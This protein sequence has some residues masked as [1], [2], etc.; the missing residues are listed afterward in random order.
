MEVRDYGLLE[1][2]LGDG[3][4]GVFTLRAPG[5]R[6]SPRLLKTCPEL[7]ASWR[8]LEALPDCNAPMRYDS[9]GPVR[10]VQALWLDELKSYEWRF[11]GPSE[12]SCSLQNSTRKADWQRVDGDTEGEWGGTLK[13][14][15]CLGTAWLGCGDHKFRFEVVTRKLSYEQ[16]YRAMVEAIARECQQLLL[17]WDAPTSLSVSA[18]AEK[19][20]RTLL[21]QFLF[22]RHVMGPDRLDVFV[23]LLQRRPHSRL[24]S[25]RH[26][27]PAAA[28]DPRL[29]IRDPLRHGRD[30]QR[31]PT[32]LINGFSPGEVCTERKFDTVDTPPNRFVKFALGRFASL[33]AQVRAL[34]AIASGQG[35]AWLEAGQMEASLESLLAAPFFHEVGELRRIPLE[36]QTLQKRAGYRDVL[37]AWLML[38]AAAQIDW[39]GRKDAYDG[40]NRNVAT[41]YEFW[42]YFTLVKMLRDNLSMVPVRDPL[43]KTGD[44]WLPFCCESENGGMAINLKQSCTSFSRFVWKGEN[45]EE[46]L[47]HLFYN[48]RF[49]GRTDV[50]KSGAYSRGFRPDFT[51]VILPAD[52]TE[53]DWRQAERDGEKDG[54]IAYLHFDAKYRIE[55]ITELLGAE[56]S[57]DDP[58]E[59]SAADAAEEREHK[60]S[61]TFK[62]ADLYKM[63][64][65]NEAIRRTAGSYV[66]FPGDAPMNSTK[67]GGNRFMRYHEVVPGV[68]AFALK[69][70]DNE[71]KPAAGLP[72]LAS[73]V[74]E[75]LRHHSSR[76]TQSYRI[77]YFTHDTVKEVP[78]VYRTGPAVPADSKPP[79]DIQ[80]LLGWV[81]DFEFAETCRRTLTFFCH[82]I[83]WDTDRPSAAGLPTKLDFDPFKSDRFVAFHQNRTCGWIAE[84]MEVRLVSAE[85]RAAQLEQPLSEMRAAYY[86]RFSL[87]NPM[88]GY[89]RD[90]SALVAKRPGKPVH[91]SLEGLAAC[92][93][94]GDI[95]CASQKP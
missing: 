77:N 92:P 84:V 45:G 63:H 49:G 68:G 69:P 56:E 50:D 58:E 39:T 41:L 14:V 88:D 21:E 10:G 79:K 29:F 57:S 17:A 90:V 22:L 46:L 38:D 53:T 4:S 35:S 73:F 86:Y 27:V 55:R 25:E 95:S 33:C 72:A 16:E 59:Q 47:V 40:T 87:R 76:F 48:R 23:E 30:W 74:E 7:P 1:I 60:A 31:T 32:V 81:R 19:Q 51:L 78:S 65:Y 18:D 64:T 15:N 28:A 6:R 70:S 12:P 75:L 26:W 80:V 43:A 66:L 67:L 37:E 71:N 34:P 11:K 62:N 2:P 61:G 44:G 82:A 8:G 93:L 20:A 94:K 89:A 13:F 24:A 3:S 42:L 85:T 91:S 5:E 54:R 36:N 83:E 9:D 52:Y